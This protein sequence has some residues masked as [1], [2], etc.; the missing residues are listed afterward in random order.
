MLIRMHQFFFIFKSDSY[1]SESKHTKHTKRLR[2]NNEYT[3]EELIHK[4]RKE[5][6]EDKDNIPLLEQEIH[7]LD[8]IAN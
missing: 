3:L 1:M 5:L 2:E 8:R 6:V 7:K 4:K